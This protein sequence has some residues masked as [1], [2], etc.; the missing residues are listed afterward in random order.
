VDQF[1]DKDEV[2]Q[3]PA[4]LANTR[5]DSIIFIY[6]DK[7]LARLA[8]KVGIKHRVATSH[9][10]YNWLYCNQIVDFSR[11]R[12]TLHESQ[13]NFKLLAP[14]KLAWDIDM[15]E[16]SSFYGLKAKEKDFSGLLSRDQFNLIIHPKSKGSAKEWGL[17]SF[18]NLIKA[19]PSGDF[20]IFIT[21]LKEE[22]EIIRKEAPELFDHA[23]VTNLTGQLNLE[24]MISF[25]GAAD[26][27]LAC[28][29][30]VLHL[31][32]ALGKYALGIYAPIK[33]VHPGRWKPIGPYATHLVLDKNCNK[34][35]RDPYCECI[36][37]ITV[38]QVK[39]RLLEF[40]KEAKPVKKYVEY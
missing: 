24:E 14:F 15:D 11:I 25:V 21:G 32:A 38:D 3:Y 23:H 12:S 6:P 30:G 29:T 18:N 5:A 26:G 35:G 28:S 10:W 37:S 16:L 9:R 40:A 33:P 4:L 1:L 34:C 2:I 13:L 7:Q 36:R 19:L 8:K 22:G 17:E 27:L 31:A 39:N 20:K